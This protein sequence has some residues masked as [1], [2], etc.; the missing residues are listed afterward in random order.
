MKRTRHDEIAHHH[1]GIPRPP[2]TTEVQA[3][4]DAPKYDKQSSATWILRCSED[5]EALSQKYRGG[6][7]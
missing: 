1:D 5:Q 6:S 2:F 4:E 3:T 7:K